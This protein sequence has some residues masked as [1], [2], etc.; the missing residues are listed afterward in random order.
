[1]SRPPI[2]VT[3]AHRSGTTWP[4]RTVALSP[5]VHYIDEI[6]NPTHRPGVCTASSGHHYLYLNDHIADS[7]GYSEALRRTLALRYDL[8]AELR[9]VR[10]PKDVARAGRDN[11]RTLVARHRDARPL[12]KDPLGFFSA[13]WLAETHRAQVVVMVR[14]PAAI[15]ASLLR[16]RWRFSFRNFLDQPE[17]MRDL[18]A[19]WEPE[20]R[21]GVD[22]LEDIVATAAL[23][24]RIIYGVADRFREDHPDWM[25]VRHEDLSSD[26]RRG[27]ATMFDYLGLELSE[28]VRARIA[29]STDT[30]NPVDAP[31]GEA[32]ALNR[33]SRANVTAWKARLDP[34]DIA[35]VRDLVGEEACRWY[36][37]DDW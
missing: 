36:G 26:P 3:G 5:A 33:D 2:L 1:M 22:L 8:G 34:A 9:S 16:M 32:H 21:D 35:R 7:T 31:T 11:W 18:L 19:D 13:P 20:I 17:L 15:A 6:F 4:A 12:L 10:T 25:F 14:H 27:F 23:L 30:G 29:A 37:S 28:P 24:W